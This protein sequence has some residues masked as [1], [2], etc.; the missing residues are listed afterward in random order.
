MSETP[1][2]PAAGLDVLR[3]RA[4]LLTRL[5]AFFAEHEIL[6]VETPLLS[7]AGLPSPQLESFAVHPVS[8]PGALTGYL[9]TSPE[10][11]MKR[12]LAAGAGPIYQV[13]RVFRADERGRRHNP[14]FSLLEWYRPG[15]DADALMAELEA[16]LQALFAG[17]RPLPPLR[18]LSYREA[19]LQYAGVDGLDTAVVPLRAALD[20]HDVP[21]PADMPADDP[22][23]WRDL[24][25]TQV[26]EP[27]LPPAVFVYD[28]PA[29][30]AALARIRPGTPPVAERFELYLDG[31]EIANGF[32]ELTDAAEQRRRFEAE[33]AARIAQGLSPLRLDTALLAA[34]EHGLPDCAG[35][36][37]GLDRVLMHAA[38]VDD[39]DAVLAFP[40]ERA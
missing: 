38:G 31:V 37:V 9:H 36:A 30:Q 12:L 16:L 28:Y 26:I 24:L 14:E 15:F 5:R 3:L 8:R 32:H 2:Q 34:L 20:D 1:W 25:L 10:F 19:F 40:W 23:P 39:I 35:V 4:Q 22:D 6:E 18:R 11:P 29:S 27:R 33:N 17:L 21:L 13:C 7:H